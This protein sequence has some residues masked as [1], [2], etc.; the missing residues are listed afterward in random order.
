MALGV[1]ISLHFSKRVYA[2]VE[3]RIYPVG[4]MPAAT[5]VYVLLAAG[6][7]GLRRSHGSTEATG[8]SWACSWGEQHGAGQPWPWRLSWVLVAMTGDLQ[9]AGGGAGGDDSWPGA[10]V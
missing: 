7:A 9:L 1:E 4:G 8:W 2:N 6:V 3:T 10:E 5:G